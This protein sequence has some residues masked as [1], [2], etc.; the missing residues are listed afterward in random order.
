MAFAPGAGVSTG[1]RRRVTGV[2]GGGVR[3]AGPA[4]V[5]LRGQVRAVARQPHRAGECRELTQGQN[6]EH[7]E[8]DDP[9]HENMI[10]TFSRSRVTQTYL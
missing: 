4:M 8:G 2:P 10:T 7:R 3:L 9:W 1:I 6:G 5:A